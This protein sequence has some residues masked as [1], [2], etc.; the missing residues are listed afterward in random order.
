MQTIFWIRARLYREAH[1]GHEA[2]PEDTAWRWKEVKQEGELMLEHISFDPCHV[3][4][5]RQWMIGPFT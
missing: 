4:T 1:E 5:C 2:N 3:G